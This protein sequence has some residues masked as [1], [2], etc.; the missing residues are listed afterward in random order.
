MISN[1]ELK[2][3]DNM[4]KLIDLF[5]AFGI[6]GNEEKIAFI[7]QATNHKIGR[8]GAPKGDLLDAARFFLAHKWQ[9]CA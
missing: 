3:V 4:E 6:S 1:D 2:K 8:S 7:E 9:S 5:N